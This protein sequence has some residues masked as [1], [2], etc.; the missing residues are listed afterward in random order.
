MFWKNLF[1]RG[2]QVCG[3]SARS[4][5]SQMDSRKINQHG[6]VNGEGVEIFIT[7]SLRDWSAGLQPVAEAKKTRRGLVTIFARA[8]ENIQGRKPPLEFRSTPS[9]LVS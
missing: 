1:S 2:T 5:L 4:G 8:T 3:Q 9:L 6:M 7:T